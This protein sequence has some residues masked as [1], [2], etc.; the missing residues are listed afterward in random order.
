MTKSLNI[1][2]ST[3]L[4]SLTGINYQS[5]LLADCLCNNKFFQDNKSG[6]INASHVSATVGNQQRFFIASQGPLPQTVAH[7]WQMIFQCDVHIIVM[8]TDVADQVS[9]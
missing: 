4:A 9:Q 3:C 2:K 7:F 8:L 6:Y 5:L 1:H